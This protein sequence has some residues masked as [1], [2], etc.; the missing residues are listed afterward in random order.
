MSTRTRRTTSS[1]PRPRSRPAARGPFHICGSLPPAKPPRVVRPRA[2]P[3]RLSGRPASAR[4][5]SSTPTSSRSTST[6]GPQ[7]AR[8]TGRPCRGCWPTWNAA[9]STTSS[10]TRS[11]VW[12]VTGPTTSPSGW[13][14]TAT[15]RSWSQPPRPSTTRQPALC[16]TASWLQSP[17]SI[18]RTWRLRPRRA[19]TRRPDVAVPLVTRRWATSTSSSGT[20][21]S[22]NAPSKS[23]RSGQPTSSG[24]STLTP[25]AS[26]LSVN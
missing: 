7:P 19:Y 20:R 24:P 17:S 23:T 26:C 2:T 16:C 15:G 3:S 6:P 11:T 18:P 12:P 1:G 9:A 5:N 4:P 22:R 14:S 13:L 25:P 8:L 21:A 10:S